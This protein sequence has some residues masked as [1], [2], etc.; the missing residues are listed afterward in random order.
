MV[1]RCMV[2][3]QLSASIGCKLGKHFFGQLNSSHYSK[4]RG[5][6]YQPRYI[7]P[8]VLLAGV[9]L[10]TGGWLPFADGWLNSC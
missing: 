7:V 10:G 2:R 9:R 8:D 1:C 3:D 5:H 4:Y 6:F